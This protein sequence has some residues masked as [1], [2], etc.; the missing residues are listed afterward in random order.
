LSSSATGCPSAE[1]AAALADAGGEVKTAIVALLTGLDP[2]AA[3][4]R[5]DQS[6]GIVRRALARP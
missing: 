6:G 4:H 3:R 1:A 5:L 2:A